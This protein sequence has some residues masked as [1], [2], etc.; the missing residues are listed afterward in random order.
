MSHREN[1]SEKT[2]DFPYKQGIVETGPT[3]TQV[4]QSQYT[5]SERN[6]IICRSLP[7]KWE[8]DER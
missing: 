4:E 1:G 5:T 6:P 8:K 2:N 3:K 7:Q